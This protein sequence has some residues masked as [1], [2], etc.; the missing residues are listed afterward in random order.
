[1][2]IK[3]ENVYKDMKNE[4][5][6]S[7]QKIEL[8]SPE[9]KIIENITKTVKEA[10]ESKKPIPKFK[11]L[12]SLL[13]S[14][15][16][17]RIS[18]FKLKI[19]NGLGF[20]LSERESI[21][22]FFE[23]IIEEISIEIK[24]KTFQW[25]SLKNKLIFRK[26]KKSRR[27]FL[28]NFK[29]KII[30]N[31]IAMILEA[32]YEPI[33]QKTDRNYGF[34]LYKSTH[35]SIK[36]ITNYNNVGLITAIKFDIMKVYDKEHPPTLA[37]VLQEYI[38]DKDFINIIFESR[39]IP[40]IMENKG[41]RIM[42]KKNKLGTSNE[43]IMSPILFN[44]YLHIFDL[45]MIKYIQNVEKTSKTQINKDC[46]NNIKIFYN[47]YA[48]NFIIL[49]NQKIENCK[50][51]IN[52]VIE[53]LKTRLKLE[54]NSLKID[55][56]D[57]TKEQIEYLG[58]SLFMTRRYKLMAKS[59]ENRSKYIIKAKQILQR[60]ILEMQK[61]KILVGI[62][63]N[64]VYNK[65]V[66]KKFA[67][68]RTLQ[69]T[70]NGL[71]GQLEIQEIIKKYNSK[72]LNIAL[73]YYKQII[74]KSTLARIIYIY[75]SS[76]IKTIAMKQKSTTRGILNTYGW[77]EY[78]LKKLPTNRHRIVFNYK[79]IKSKNE[80]KNNF[81]LLL[82]YRD[83]MAICR[84]LKFESYLI[85]NNG[86]QISIENCEIIEDYNEYYPSMRILINKRLNSWEIK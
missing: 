6:K 55:I 49:T 78:N 40:K 68:S 65:L 77:K 54:V 39:M 73:Y 48:D 50:E 30:Q 72:M 53:I 14:K 59:F 42:I 13:G 27:L 46:L 60:N 36:A 2:R 63:L 35:N 82:N 18:Y 19:K 32:I 67:D 11:N 3:T 52:F 4:K 22:N 58:F 45:E 7:N 74:Y 75:Y 70:F 23:N 17:M 21:E 85:V 79:M 1:M 26:E 28:P 76:C 80:I 86:T 62:D 25:K 29:E 9:L 44:I 71:L 64:R 5:Q 51:F 47:R 83:I 8:A 84:I 38:D 56:K 37:K 20:L 31:M 16:L 24:N 15:N 12:Y 10:I 43:S 69:P 66:E 81:V 57:I 33:F 61:K 41:R 34:R